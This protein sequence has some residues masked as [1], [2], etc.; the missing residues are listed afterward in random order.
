MCKTWGETR[1]RMECSSSH[2][3]H[4]E[5]NHAARTLMSPTG[6]TLSLCSL[7]YGRS[8][9][10]YGCH[11]LDENRIIIHIHNTAKPR[12]SLYNLFR[13]PSP[14]DDAVCT[15]VENIMVNEKICH[16]RSKP[17]M[18]GSRKPTEGATKGGIATRK[19]HG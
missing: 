12:R 10:D 8:H 18:E 16:K 13:L 7:R 4:P 3:G 14:S 2:R 11:L 19:E 5:A 6:A 9:H 17:V 15:L 1:D